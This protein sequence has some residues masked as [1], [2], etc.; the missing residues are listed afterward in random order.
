MSVKVDVVW[1]AEHEDREAG[2]PNTVWVIRHRKTFYYYI[3]T[4]RAE[5]ERRFRDEVATS[6]GFGLGLAEL[7]GPVAHGYSASFT[8]QFVTWV[9]PGEQM[10]E[11]VDRLLT[12]AD[13][14]RAGE[15]ER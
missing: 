8:D 2:Q 10:Q 1:Q 7:D 9:D 3:N 15:V 11:L 12:S 5:A 13:I 6:G 14:L 4:G